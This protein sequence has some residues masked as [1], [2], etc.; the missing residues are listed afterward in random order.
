MDVKIEVKRSKVIWPNLQSMWLRKDLISR[1]CILDHC[2]CIASILKIN[3]VR[4]SFNF[5]LFQT[6]Y[7][8]FVQEYYLLYFDLN[9]RL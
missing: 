7:H 6:Q 1:I 9:S 4:I 8:V 2:I 5:D 3:L